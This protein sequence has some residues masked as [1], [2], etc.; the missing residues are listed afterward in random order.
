LTRSVL[1]FFV[2]LLIS[3][4]GIWAAILSPEP[5]RPAPG[6]GTPGP[7]T[8]GAAMEGGAHPPVELPAEVKTFMADLAK[9]ADA[10]PEDKDL[11]VRLG[12]V[13]SRAAQLDP[14]YNPKALAAFEHV[15]ARDPNDRV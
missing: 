2:L 3:G 10:A 12:K 13:Y 7:V 9:K 11:W 6:R 8:A 1:A 15:L 4:L 5:P 14:S